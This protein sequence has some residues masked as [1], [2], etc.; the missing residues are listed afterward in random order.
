MKIPEKISNL[1][2]K[3]FT[4][5]ENVETLQGTVSILVKCSFSYQP[6]FW[7]CSFVEGESSWRYWIETK[8]SIV[9]A[10]GEYSVTIQ[11]PYCLSYKDGKQNFIT[12]VKSLIYCDKVYLNCTKGKNV[13]IRI[14]TYDVWLAGLRMSI[15]KL[16]TCFW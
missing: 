11:L 13:P 3:A 7:F 1:E 8:N 12:R 5:E 14:K 10:S 9:F 2:N 6:Y 4:L 15:M 16:T